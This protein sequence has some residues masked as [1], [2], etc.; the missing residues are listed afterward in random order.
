LR[1]MVPAYVIEKGQAVIDQGVKT[2]GDPTNMVPQPGT[3][4]AT[5]TPQPGQNGSAPAG[6]TGQTQGSN[7]NP[8]GNPDGQ[9]AAAGYKDAQRNDLDRLIE[10]SQ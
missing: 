3:Q 9:A 5:A 4:P 7:A 8:S 6:G 2:L 10:S 1:N